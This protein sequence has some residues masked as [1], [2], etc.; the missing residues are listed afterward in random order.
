VQHAATGQGHCMMRARATREAAAAGRARSVVPQLHMKR[1]VL[2]SA[3][4]SQHAA[5][6]CQAMQLKQQLQRAAA[7]CRTQSVADTAA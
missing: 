1:V 5:D 4:P 2:G 7:Q 6:V 3:L